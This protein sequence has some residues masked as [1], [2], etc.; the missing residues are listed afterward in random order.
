MSD[1]RT[2]AYALLLAM[3]L[4]FSSNLIIGRAA[5]E[6]VEPWMLA[7]LRW[8]VAFAIL[9]PFAAQGLVR[10]RRTL[11]GNW[12]L[13]GIMGVLGM[14]IC[15]AGVYFAL[16]FT[17]A[18]NG[19]LIYTS[20]PVL[21]LL[22]EWLFRGRRIALREWIGIVLAIT[23]VVAIVVKGSFAALLAL[24]LNAG[25][26]VFALA[27]ISW[28]IYSVLLKRQELAEVPT[29][30]LF[31]ALALAGAISLLPFSIWEYAETGLFPDTLGAWGSIAGVALIAS[32]LAF[33]C[34]QYGIKVV[35]PATTGLF[36]YLLPPYGVMM[37]VLFLGEEL[38]LFHI[39][40]FVLIMTGLVLATAP[41]SIFA[42]VAERLRALASKEGR[43]T[44]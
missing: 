23:G 5:V 10:Y 32:V 30:S 4:F 40:G 21:I 26:V 43:T 41:K 7:F 2:R 11:L 3:P 36:M 39:G 37:A 38:H 9:L 31:A 16:R 15:G 33:T 44:R 8:I 25:D 24:D 28:A 6:S 17:T 29:V 19:T 18:T 20:S 13:I 12:E 14:W 42:R 22:L 27:A 35:G 1:E 34:F